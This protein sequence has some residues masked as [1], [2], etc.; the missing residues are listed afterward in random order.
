MVFLLES[1][2]PWRISCYASMP[3]LEQMECACASE[4]RQT[5]AMIVQVSFLGQAEGKE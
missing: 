3:L 4:Q 5:G 1:F 2:R